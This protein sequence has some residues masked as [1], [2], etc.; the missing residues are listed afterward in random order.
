MEE[1][2]KKIPEDV[3]D[4]EKGCG[5][6]FDN[7]KVYY[8][9]A[10]GPFGVGGKNLQKLVKTRFC[11]TKWN[12]KNKNIFADYPNPISSFTDMFRKETNKVYNMIQQ[13]CMNKKYV[14]VWLIVVN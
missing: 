8:G 6:C 10:S 12:F 3:I 7:K 4:G 2:N 9:D 1:Q 11:G 5:F 13:K 14:K